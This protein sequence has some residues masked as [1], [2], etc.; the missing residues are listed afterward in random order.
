[1]NMS[2]FFA[3]LNFVVHIHELGAWGRGRSHLLYVRM[4]IVGLASIRERS[5]VE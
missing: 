1:M 3:L 2:L 5:R 4:R